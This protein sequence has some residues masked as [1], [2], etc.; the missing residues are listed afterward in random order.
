MMRWAAQWIGSANM[1]TSTKFGIIAALERE[2]RPWLRR[3]QRIRSTPD[4]AFYEFS[5]AVAVCGGIG[6]AA[7]AR[8]TSALVDSCRP[9]ILISAGFAGAVN[10][11]LKVADLLTPVEIVDVETGDTFRLEAGR[12]V[13]ATTGHIADKGYKA[14]LSA[15]GVSAVDMEAA[16][17]AQVARE[18]G[19]RFLALK[20]I[21]DDAEFAMPPMDRFLSEAGKFRTASFLTHVALRPAMWPRVKRLA[22]NS[23]RAALVLS[24]ALD[25]LLRE[26]II[27]KTQIGA[28]VRVDA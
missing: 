10:S 8:A 28:I 1:A 24:D 5:D 26:A 19:L 4:Y 3:C 25:T 21:S 6:K 23:A 2:L 15:R 12:G 16:A 14:M 27:G 11:D 20:A 22:A 17:V 9:S 7:A 13:L 18:N